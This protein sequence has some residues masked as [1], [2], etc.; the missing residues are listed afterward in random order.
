[1]Y[2]GRPGPP[3]PPNRPVPP[4]GH[5]MNPRPNLLS[6]FQTPDGKLDFEKIAVT[7]QQMNRIYSQAK[8]IIAE[9]IK[10]KR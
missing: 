9:F 6:Q 8:P 5:Q 10:K 4:Q 1:M 7:A 3:M 2:P